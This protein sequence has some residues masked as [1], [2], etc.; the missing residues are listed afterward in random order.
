MK[1]LLDQRRGDLSYGAFIKQLLTEELKSYDEGFEKGREEGLEE[2]HDEGYAEGFTKGRE[3]GLE[4]GH[5]E[6]YTEGY[7]AGCAIGRE[8]SVKDHTDKEHKAWFGDGR[9]FGYIEGERDYEIWL[10]CSICGMPMTIRPNSPSHKA[11]IQLALQ[12]GWRHVQCPI[13]QY[14]QYPQYR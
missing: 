11:L 2:G 13:P 8:E 3:E 14:P 10:Y 1:A 5:E 12:N 9:K 4:K 7:E 6:G